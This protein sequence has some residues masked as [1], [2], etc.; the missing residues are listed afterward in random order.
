MDLLILV[1]GT[2]KNILYLLE[3][4]STF[5]ILTSTFGFLHKYSFGTHILLVLLQARLQVILEPTSKLVI[6]RIF[7]LYS[8]C[9]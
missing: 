6:K 1:F 8:G 9:T 7:V 2:F 4:T 3:L 5:S